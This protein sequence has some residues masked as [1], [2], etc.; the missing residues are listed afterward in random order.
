MYSVK[1]RFVLTVML[2]TWLLNCKFCIVIRNATILNKEIEMS[3]AVPVAIVLYMKVKFN[4]GRSSLMMTCFA[5]LYLSIE[6]V[7]LLH[8]EFV[9]SFS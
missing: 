6:R 1:S 7:I 4:K 8:C 5:I 9:L 2:A 3:S